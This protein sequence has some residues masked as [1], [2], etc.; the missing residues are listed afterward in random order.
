MLADE[1]LSNLRD[2]CK[3]FE[4]RKARAH[5]R[6]RAE[7][8]SSR[9]H[10]GILGLRLDAGITE[11]AFAED[12]VL[13]AVIEPPG[14]VELASHLPDAAMLSAVARYSPSLG[15]ELVVPEDFGARPD[16]VLTLAWWFVS[17]LRVRT[18]AQILVPV[19][20]TRSWST[21]SAVP[22]GDCAIHLVEDVSRPLALTAAAPTP[23][24]AAE[25]DWVTANLTNVARALEIPRVRLA[26]DALTTHPHEASLRTSTA[27]LWAGIEAIFA[28][29]TELRFR[30]SALERRSC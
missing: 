28:V 8:T 16:A 6:L 14:L 1:E 13:R 25:L 24:T 15:H 10:F 9:R 4:D 17:L 29:T 21:L 7:P 26:V 5:D 22:A 11:Y 19:V 12:I 27:S 3:Y 23:V 2:L 18:R 30:L 20:S